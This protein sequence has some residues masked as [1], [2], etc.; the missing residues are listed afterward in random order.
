MLVFQYEDIYSA[1][2]SAAA[3]IPLIE[4]LHGMGG[5]AKTQLFLGKRNLFVLPLPLKGYLIAF[6][7]LQK[8]L[9]EL[10]KF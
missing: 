1:N 4:E 3:I 7:F 8:I 5:K 10:A 2:K 9:P 6:I